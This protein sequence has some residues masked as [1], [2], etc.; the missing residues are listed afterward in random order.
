MSPQ[1]SYTSRLL[2]YVFWNSGVMYALLNSEEEE[3]VTWSLP[4]LPFLVL[5]RITPLAAL[6]PYNAAADGPL[7]TE[8]DSISS[9]LK[10]A[11]PSVPALPSPMIPLSEPMLLL[12]NGIPSTTYNA[13]LLPSSDLAPRITTR[14]EPPTPL[15]LLLIVT[16]AILP[17]SEFTKLASLTRVNSSLFTCCTLY[18]RAFSAR[19]IPRAVTTTS[20]SSREAGFIANL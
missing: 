11:I 3:K 10:S 4:S 6:L 17:L 15:P 1:L 8:I 12:N 18:D 19:L 16:P 20:L 14:V 7:S 9:G 5:I 13:L 2:P